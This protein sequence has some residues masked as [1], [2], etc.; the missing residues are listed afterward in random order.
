MILNETKQQDIS[1]LS[2]IFE[3]SEESFDFQ[4]SKKQSLF[5]KEAF[6][7]NYEEEQTN[8]K[9]ISVLEDF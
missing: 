6:D 2:N 3:L 1:Q 7:Y 8:E 4:P 9:V 5:I